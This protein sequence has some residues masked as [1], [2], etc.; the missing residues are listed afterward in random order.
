M[1]TGWGNLAG[2][3]I[4]KLSKGKGIGRYANIESEWRDKLKF[5]D[6]NALM[7]CDDIVRID[8]PGAVGILSSNIR[9]FGYDYSNSCTGRECPKV[10]GAP[11]ERPNGIELRIFDNFN[12][13]HIKDLLR[14]KNLY[15]SIDIILYTYT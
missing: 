1:A 10:S 8:E 4:R 12:S 13:K 14:A 6:S 11:M 2:S 5:K 15:D 7:N 9:T 3:D